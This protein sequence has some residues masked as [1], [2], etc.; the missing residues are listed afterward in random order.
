MMHVKLVQT[1]YV[2]IT[3]R[4]QAEEGRGGSKEVSHM[5][6]YLRTPN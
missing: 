2:T 1:P 6:T 4:R 3:R 5:Y